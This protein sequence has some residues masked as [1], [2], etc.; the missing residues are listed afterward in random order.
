MV[1]IRYSVKS[2][3][4]ELLRSIDFSS[5]SIVSSLRLLKSYGFLVFI[6]FFSSSKDRTPS[7]FVSASIKDFSNGNFYVDVKTCETT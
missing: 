5:L 6:R 4:P 1:A 2:I 7:E 3:S